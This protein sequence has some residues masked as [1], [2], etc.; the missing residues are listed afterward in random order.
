MTY[1]EQLDLA[2]KE[3]GLTNEK[4]AVKADLTS[5]T[6]S[7]VRRGERTVVLETLDKVAGALGMDVVIELVPKGEAARR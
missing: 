3:N 4:L 1:T 2:I 5:T 6:I 7:R